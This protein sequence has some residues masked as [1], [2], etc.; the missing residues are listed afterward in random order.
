MVGSFQKDTEGKKYWKC[1]FCKNYNR[2]D[3]SNKC[4]ECNKFNSNIKLEYYPKLS[5]GPDL[6]VKII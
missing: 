3:D 5:K 6:F 4:K 1:A 2:E